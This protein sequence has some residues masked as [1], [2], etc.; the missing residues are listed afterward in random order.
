MEE[1]KEKLFI[2]QRPKKAQFW[3]LKFNFIA[4]QQTL[5]GTLHLHPD[6]HH[7]HTRT[8]SQDG[9][10][11]TIRLVTWLCIRSQVVGRHVESATLDRQGCIRLPSTR[12]LLLLHHQHHPST[13]Q[14]PRRVRQRCRHCASASQRG[15]FVEHHYHLYRNSH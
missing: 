10:L 4:K 2:S 15:H 5:I 14:I 1:R 11:I 3:I 8:A 6:Y 9:G 13:L 7:H 12:M